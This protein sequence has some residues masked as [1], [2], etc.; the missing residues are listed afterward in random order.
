MKLTYSNRRA[1]PWQKICHHAS[2]YEALDTILEKTCKWVN[3]QQSQ[4]TTTI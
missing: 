4:S 3:V 2:W 1:S